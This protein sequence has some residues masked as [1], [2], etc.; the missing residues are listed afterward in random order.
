MCKYFFLQFSMLGQN[1][2]GY[3]V[4]MCVRW[5][6]LVLDSGTTYF[7]TFLAELNCAVCFTEQSHLNI[8]DKK[9]AKKTT[10]N[11]AV[12]E[13]HLSTCC[14]VGCVAASTFKTR[15]CSVM[16]LVRACTPAQA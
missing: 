6:K 9:P 14:T 5:G 16:N 13:S 11:F 8:K 4:N 10:N 15:S 7:L 1:M 12:S 3:W 2:F